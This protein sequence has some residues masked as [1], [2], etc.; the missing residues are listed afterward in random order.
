MLMDRSAELA[1]IDAEI[2][3]CT[4]CPLATTRTRAVPGEGPLDAEVLFIGE[5]PGFHEDRQG[6]PFVGPAGDFLNELLASVGLARESVYITNV[7]KCRPPQNREPAPDEIGTCVPTYLDRQLALI[8]PLLIV[9]LGRFSMARFF[10]GA[11][12]SRIHGRPRRE[13]TRIIYPMLHPAAALHRAE[14]REVVK[15]DM[16]RIPALLEE[17]RNLAAETEKPASEQPDDSDP[18]Q[19]S[20]F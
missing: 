9:T 4:L 12:I 18:Q 8:A 20:M 14:L 19:L 16:L 15:Q 7:V 5:G 11:S 17:A 2:L 1:A 10:P 6:R 3:G 13:A